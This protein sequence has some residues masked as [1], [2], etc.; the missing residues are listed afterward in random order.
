MLKENLL[1][2]YADSFKDH[3]SL[4]ALTDYITKELRGKENCLQ[5]LL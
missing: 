3:W 2:I 5:R 1:S 4:P